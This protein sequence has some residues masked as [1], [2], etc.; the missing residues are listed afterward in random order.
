M[1]T[2]TI[3]IVSCF[4]LSSYKFVIVF[5]RLPGLLVIY[6]LCLDSCK[7]SATLFLWLMYCHVKI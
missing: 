5:I 2:F 7:V 1:C 4:S 6:I 3:I